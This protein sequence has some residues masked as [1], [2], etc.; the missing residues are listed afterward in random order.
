MTIIVS[1]AILASFLS[2]CKEK[3]DNK[4]NNSSAID[5]GPRPVFDIP[6]RERPVEL[7]A[8]LHNIYG[9]IA[10]YENGLYLMAS[11]KDE[12]YKRQLFFCNL[13]DGSV[14]LSNLMLD[15]FCYM[16]IH[17]LSDGSLLVGGFYT[18]YDD[19]ANPIIS[20]D[21]YQVYHLSEGHKKLLL[22]LPEEKWVNDFYVNEN[23]KLLYFS[24]YDFSTGDS[25]I[26]VYSLTGNFIFLTISNT[27]I[28]ET[29]FSEKDNALYIF[30]VSDEDEDIIVMMFDEDERSIIEL[31]CLPNGLINVELHNSNIY[32]FYAEQ[33]SQVWGFDY[34]SKTFT[35]VLNL[36]THGF[37][38]SVSFFYLYNKNYIIY[39]FDVTKRE[40][41]IYKIMITDEY[42]GPAEK[43]R[44]GK[45]EL[46]RDVFLEGAVADFN[47]YN[48]QYLVEIVDY[49]VYGDEALMQL[50]MDIIQGNSPDIIL[51]AEPLMQNQFLPLHQYINTGLLLNIAPYMERDL[52]F[53]TLWSGAMQ[54]LYMD[55]SCY[56]AVPSFALYGFIGRSAAMNDLMNDSFN[57]LLEYLKSDIINQTKKFTTNLTQSDFIINLILTNINQFVNYDTGEAF[58]DSD[59]FIALLE[60][61]ML[62]V[63]DDEWD[64]VQL[65]KG[66]AELAMLHFDAFGQL[67]SYTSVLNN[68]ITASGFSGNPPGVAMVPRN[69]FGISSGTTNIEGA[70]AFLRDL[71]ENENLYENP[72]TRFSMNRESFEQAADKY[73][74]IATDYINEN[75]EGYLIFGNDF[76]I[77]VPHVNPVDVV[78]H[79][80]SLIEQI[81]RVYLVDQ[82]LVNI[83]LEELPAFFAGSTSAANTARALQSRAQV[84][85]WELK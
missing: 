78:N 29:I 75:K 11:L 14:T 26:D 13:D 52:D 68:D 5:I 42:D 66:A 74:D 55:D 81:D 40:T 30:C 1:L 19:D 57:D 17:A 58:F 23:K 6:Q 32:S 46:G 67:A 82:S 21:N 34:A 80:R 9:V 73:I 51:L 79:T 50:H 70:W 31:S 2:A 41:K 4:E 85:L 43:L 47:F 20:G 28:H 54:A 63:P 77:L 56:I 76:G 45:F 53:D 62:L 10:P 69:I 12:D 22:E 36:T 18:E 48:P 27:R 71:Y 33:G 61:A 8:E 15:N 38:G 44:L 25:Q 37:S 84:Y 72:Y 60:T 39:E 59:E 49:S 35:E 16:Q 83:I 65:A 64:A 3:Y 24:I 7:F